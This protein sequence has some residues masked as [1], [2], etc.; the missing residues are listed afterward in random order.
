MG[1]GA[2]LDI[3]IYGPETD[4]YAVRVFGVAADA[5]IQSEANL[6]AQTASPVGFDYLLNH[7]QRIAIHTPTNTNRVAKIRS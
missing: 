1:D 4:P 7:N 6:S 5:A 3:T 2:F